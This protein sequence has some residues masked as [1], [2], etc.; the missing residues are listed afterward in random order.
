MANVSQIEHKPSSVSDGA[1]MLIQRNHQNIGIVFAAGAERVD[2]IEFTLLADPQYFKK[3][4][5]SSTDISI[6]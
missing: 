3:L 4:V 5:S 6:Q 1:D 2:S